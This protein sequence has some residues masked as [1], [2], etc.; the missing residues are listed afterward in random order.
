M[1][2][3]QDEIISLIRLAFNVKEV[4]LN[5]SGKKKITAEFKQDID[6]GSSVGKDLKKAELKKEYTKPPDGVMTKGER[7]MKGMF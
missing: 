5:Y 7:T 3:D 1:T 6:V 4:K 2:L